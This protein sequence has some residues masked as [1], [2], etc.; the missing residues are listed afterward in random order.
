VQPAYLEYQYIKVSGVDSHPRFEQKDCVSLFIRL[1]LFSGG[2]GSQ[3]SS[4]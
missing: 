1:F 2:L 3:L 4:I